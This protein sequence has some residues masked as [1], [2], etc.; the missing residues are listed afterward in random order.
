MPIYDLVLAA[1]TVAFVAVAWFYWRSAAASV[2]HPATLYLAFHGLV[3]VVRPIFARVYDFRT[4]YA[5]VGF[6]PSL[7]GQMIVWVKTWS[8]KTYWLLRMK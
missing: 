5:S 8:R 1:S 2:F 6:T 4:I 7:S 3:F